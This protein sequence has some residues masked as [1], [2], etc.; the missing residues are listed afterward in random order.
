L[1][2]NATANQL[3]SFVVNKGLKVSSCTLLTDLEKHPDS[4]AKS[5]KVTI[6]ADDY[7]KALDE[8]MWPY[9]VRVRLFKHFR[10]NQNDTQKKQMEQLGGS[11]DSN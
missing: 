7:E 8:N 10:K 5:F 1:S 11:G 6:K 9:R 2:L 3:E 4:R